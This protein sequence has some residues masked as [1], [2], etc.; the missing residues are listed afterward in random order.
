MYENPYCC[1]KLANCASLILNCE[2]PKEKVTLTLSKGSLLCSEEPATD[3]YCRTK[4]FN[5]HSAL[6][7]WCALTLQFIV[8]VDHCR[9]VGNILW[10]GH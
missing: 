3:Y 7:S 6:P 1:I 5:P 4:K 10:A 2:S 8:L 9:V